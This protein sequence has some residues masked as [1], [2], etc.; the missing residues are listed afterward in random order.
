MPVGKKK[1]Q[2]FSVLYIEMQVKFYFK[3]NE[4]HH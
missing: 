3:K 2:L 4:Y 1:L